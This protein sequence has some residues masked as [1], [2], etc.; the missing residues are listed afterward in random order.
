MLSFNDVSVLLLGP[1]IIA[2]FQ[3]LHSQDRLYDKALRD[4]LESVTIVDSARFTT[5]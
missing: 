5:L 1:N 4:V 3:L 2:Y